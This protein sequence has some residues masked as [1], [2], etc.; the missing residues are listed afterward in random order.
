MAYDVP[1]IGIDADFQI[2]YSRRRN[3]ESTWMGLHRG[4]RQSV[5]PAGREAFGC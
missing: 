5:I 2:A 1:K 3:D 4:F